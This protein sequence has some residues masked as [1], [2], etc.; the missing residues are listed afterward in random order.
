[1]GPWY[2]FFS[3]LGVFVGCLVSCKKDNQDS[4][5]SRQLVGVWVDV[6]H[7]SDTLVFYKGDHGVLM[8]DNSMSFRSHPDPEAVRV[9][10][11]WQVNLSEDGI[12]IAPTDP[13]FEIE[14]SGSTAHPFTWLEEGKKFELPGIAFRYWM[15]C[16]NCLVRYQK[17]R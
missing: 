10:Y 16:N 15:S 4:V 17:I 8:F 12:R 2:R 11:T 5:A 6:D 13:G 3:L 9:A 14:L 7:V 1:M